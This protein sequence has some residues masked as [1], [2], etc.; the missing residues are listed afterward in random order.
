MVIF[1]FIECFVDSFVVL[2]VTVGHS[3]GEQNDI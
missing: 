1:V 3:E 2:D